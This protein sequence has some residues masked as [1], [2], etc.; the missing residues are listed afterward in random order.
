M[1]YH[2][3]FLSGL[4]LISFLGLQNRPEGSQDPT[5]NVISA[6]DAGYTGKEITVAVVDDGVDGNHPELKDN[7]VIN[8]GSFLCFFF[9]F[10]EFKWTLIGLVGNEVNYEQN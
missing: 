3:D 2:N 4:L 1:E 8:F 9:F 7:Y 10:I 6:W 5:F